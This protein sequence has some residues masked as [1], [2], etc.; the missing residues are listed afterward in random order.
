MLLI[1]GRKSLSGRW[2][3]A[4]AWR[5]FCDDDMAVTTHKTTFC[6]G[7]CKGCIL[8]DDATAYG[9][10][11]SVLARLAAIEWFALVAQRLMAFMTLSRMHR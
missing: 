3:G 5:R 2:L 10:R 9:V 6:K 7:V 1:F 8:R 4:S 11:C